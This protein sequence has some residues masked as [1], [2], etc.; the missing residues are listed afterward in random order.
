MRMIIIGAGI[1]GTMAY[2][3]F[4]KYSPMVYEAKPNRTAFVDSDAIVRMKD[5]AIGYLFGTEVKEVEV[6][7]WIWDNGKY[8]SVCNP[9]FSCS[10][11][12]KVTGTGAIIGRSIENL[13]KVKRYLINPKLNISEDQ[14]KFGYSFVGIEAKGKAIVGKVQKGEKQKDGQVLD[15]DVV[16][17]DVLIN[18]T[19]LPFLFDMEGIEIDNA[20]ELLKDE[21]INFWE[22]KIFTRNFPFQRL[23]GAHINKYYTVYLPGFSDYTYDI[24]RVNLS[25]AGI[26]FESVHEAYQLEN[27]DKCFDLIQKLFGID[28]KELGDPDP[29]KRIGESKIRD[30]NSDLRK[31]ILYQI[32]SRHNIYSLGRYAIWKNIG[33]DDLMKDVKRIDQMIS[34]QSDVLN[35]DLHGGKI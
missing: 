11:S 22:A 32:T 33:V 27:N 7:K 2:N 9:L 16:G 17:Y 12:Q 20:D 30:M 18:T 3:Y 34:V 5:P 1:A 13:G 29:V 21:D 19:P 15:V 8:Y 28:Q 23:V 6:E 31:R 4:R 26:K 10:Y 14:I 35:Y 25:P 24:Y